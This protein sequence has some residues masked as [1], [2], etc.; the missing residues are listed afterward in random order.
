MEI[1]GE[2]FR[3]IATDGDVYLGGKDWDLKLVDIAAERFRAAHREDP[4][5]QPESL[6]DSYR[7]V[8]IAKKTLSERDKAVIVINHLGTRFKTTITRKEFEEATLSLLE[9]TRTTTE[10]VVRQAG[11]SWPDIDKCSSSA[12]QHECRW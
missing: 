6:F 11:L 10:I 7:A 4:R 3:T 1:A 8:E 9:R 12:D 2:T 5:Q